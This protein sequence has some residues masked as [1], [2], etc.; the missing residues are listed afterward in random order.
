MRRI[1]YGRQLN[2]CLG[3]TARNMFVYGLCVAVGVL[4]I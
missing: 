1:N 2:E 3:E 4:L